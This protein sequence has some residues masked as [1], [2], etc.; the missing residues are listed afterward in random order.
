PS[1]GKPDEILTWLR[2]QDFGDVVAVVLSTDMVAYGGLVASRVPDTTAVEAE[3]RLRRLA[4]I[5]SR[6]PRVPFYGFSA[7][8]RLYPTST[9]GNAAWRLQLGRYAELKERFERTGEPASRRSM[10]NLLARIPP[11]EIVRYEETRA[12]NHEIQRLLIRMTRSGTFDYLILGQDDAQPFGPHIPEQRA[13]A[14]YIAAQ[15]VQNK[16]YQCEGIDQHANVLVSR[17][18]LRRNGWTPRVRIVY[19]DPAGRHKIANYES[20]NVENSLRDQI[21]ASGA[22][23]AI[24][25]DEYD[26]TLYVNTP[27]PRPEEFANFLVKLKDDVDQGFPVAVADINLGKDGTADSR[28]FAGLMTNE[29]MVRLLSYAGWNTA[30]NTMG[31]TIPTANVY[32]LARR[33][34]VDPLV[35][36]VA[37]REFLLHRYVN[38]FEYHRYVRPLAYQM[39]DEMPRASREEAYG[40]EFADVDQFVRDTLTQH[41][42]RVFREQFLGRSFFAG[43]GQFVVSGLENVRVFLPWPRVYEVRLEFRMQ[44]VSAAEWAASQSV[45]TNG[46]G[47]GTGSDPAAP[48]SPDPV[49]PVPGAPPRPPNPDRP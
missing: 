42:D 35:R 2:D 34:Q 16:V 30:G 4:I 3:R 20:K 47:V 37:R 49:V 39:I 44:A 18:L 21:L 32:L 6:H 10:Q 41:L 27:D 40:S 33:M 48:V 1:P 29:R 11:L 45:V 17:A 13:L 19:S 9:R 25:P 28:L 38:D 15:G 31:T 8:M 12:R 36:E 26:Y 7:V 5:R 22:R 23:P 24:N 14:R 43:T 46:D